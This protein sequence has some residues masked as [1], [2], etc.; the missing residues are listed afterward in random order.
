[1]IYVSSFQAN[2]TTIPVT[3]E[4]VE[5]YVGAVLDYTLRKG[6]SRQVEAFRQGEVALYWA[7]I[8]C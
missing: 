7:A 1:M 5:E 3:L 6:I 8:V 4:N 2:G